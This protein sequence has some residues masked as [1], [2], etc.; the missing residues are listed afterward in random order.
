MAETA[1][2]SIE[3]VFDLRSR[4]GLLAVGRVVAGR[5]SAGMTLQ[6][7]STGQRVRVLGVEFLTPKARQLGRTT[8]V[9]ERTSPTPVQPGRVLILPT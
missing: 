3:E 4:G 1:Q 5:I 9:L 2:F 8:L 7:P 6:D